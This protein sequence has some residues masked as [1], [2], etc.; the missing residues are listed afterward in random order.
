[1]IFAAEIFREFFIRNCTEIY[2]L[3][4]A[5]DGKSGGLWRQK[6]AAC[7]ASKDKMLGVGK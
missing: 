5:Y 7:S 3:T 2:F 4:L 1:M 6:G